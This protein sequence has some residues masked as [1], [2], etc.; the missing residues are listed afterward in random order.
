MAGIT[1]ILFNAV[2]TCQAAERDGEWESV[3]EMAI[4][5]EIVTVGARERRREPE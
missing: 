4:E 2:E 1:Q 3:V 5:K